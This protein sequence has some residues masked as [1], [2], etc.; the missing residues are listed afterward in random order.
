MK[1]AAEYE[2]LIARKYPEMGKFYRSTRLFTGTK[3]MDAQTGIHAVIILF[4]FLGNV[5]FLLGRRQGRT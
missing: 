1:G 5:A 2:Q 4:I 3:G